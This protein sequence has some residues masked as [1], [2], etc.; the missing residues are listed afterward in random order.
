M[1]GEWAIAMSG[2]C[3]YSRMSHSDIGSAAVC[4]TAAIT[5]SLF[6]FPGLALE[7]VHRI[8]T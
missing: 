8:P 4:A 1:A 5:V 6:L 7:L 2:V 3:M